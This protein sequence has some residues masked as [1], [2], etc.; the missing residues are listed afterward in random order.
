MFCVL[1]GQSDHHVQD[2]A[3]GPAAGRGIPILLHGNTG[4]AVDPAEVVHQAFKKLCRVGDV[5]SAGNDPAH[6]RINRTAL[7]PVEALLAGQLLLAL[8]AGGL[9]DRGAAPRPREVLGSKGQDYRAGVALPHFRLLV[10]HGL[11]V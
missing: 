5:R 2:A 9:E 6:E 7:D 8:L 4:K 11:P 3:P 10:A 1:G